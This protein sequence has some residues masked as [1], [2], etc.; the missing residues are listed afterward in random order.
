ME[1]IIKLCSIF[2]DKYNTFKNKIGFDHEYNENLKNIEFEITDNINS[3]SYDYDNNKVIIPSEMFAQENFEFNFYKIML[4]LLTTKK[5]DGITFKGV[6]YYNRNNSK[7]KGI[8]KVLS[9]YICNSITGVDCSDVNRVFMTKLEKLID[10]KELINI[11]FNNDISTLN[12]YF[13]EI[14]IDL[15]MLSENMDILYNMN[16]TNTNLYN[17]IGTIIDKTLLD[18]IIR[19]QQNSGIIDY[20]L[21]EVSEGITNDYIGFEGIKDNERYYYKKIRDMLPNNNTLKSL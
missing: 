16:S 5:E 15:D 6:S 9:N 14:G 20:S 11:Y 8:N 2:C 7:N 12:S 21:I 10:P 18:A 4:E 19:K 17:N 1:N 3:I 13:N